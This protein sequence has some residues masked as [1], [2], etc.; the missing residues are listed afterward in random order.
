MGNGSRNNGFGSASARHEDLNESMARIAIITADISNKADGVTDYSRLLA[1]E[2]RRQQHQVMLLGLIQKESGWAECAE[3]SFAA[4]TSALTDWRSRLNQAREVIDEF[5][6]DFAS[7]QYVCFSFGRYGLPLN[8]GRDLRQVIGARP[9][10]LMSHELWTGITVSTD[11]KTYFLGTLQQHFYMRFLRQLQ[12]GYINVSNPAYVLLLKRLGINATVLPL[13]GNIPVTFDQ[14]SHILQLMNNCNSGQS[15]S[16]LLFGSIHPEW[17][18]EPLL[19]MIIETCRKHRKKPVM[20]SVGSQGRGSRVWENM[21]HKY[22]HEVQFVKLGM[23]DSGRISALMNTCDFGVVT[24]PLSLIG[25][26]GT[27]AAM[28]EHDMPVIANRDDA[29][30]GVGRVEP[31]EGWAR[32]IFLDSS[33]ENRLTNELLRQRNPESRLPIIASKMIKE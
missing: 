22:H 1:G 25:K 3:I 17:P 18:P 5:S 21:V 19:S 4:K 2:L 8:I 26:S 10:Q 30:Y 11:I 9:V 14:D 12:P 32:F 33:F 16:F 13:F 28:L 24:S 27:A 15:W 29:C 23:V 20:I 7:L 6:P 31:T